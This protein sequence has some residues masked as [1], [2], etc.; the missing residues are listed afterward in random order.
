M[1]TP[2]AL[3][4]QTVSGEIRADL[5]RDTGV[6]LFADSKTG[7]VS[8][9]VSSIQAT[10]GASPQ[11]QTRLGKGG[12]T[13]K[14]LSQA[15][16]V[17]V[18]IRGESM[19]RIAATGPTTQ[20]EKRQAIRSGDLPAPTQ[21]PELIGQSKSTIA[22]GT[23]ANPTNG[24]EEISEGD[25]IRVD[26]ELVSVNVSV[27]DRNTNRGVNDLSKEDF[28]LFED[29]APQQIAHFD[30]AS[31]PFNLVLLIDLSGSTAKVVELIKAAAQHFVEAARP[32]DRIGD[33]TFPGGQVLVS[34][35]TSAHQP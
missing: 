33:V 13:V 31:A 12:R 16:N 25:V 22:A 1:G 29:N 7:A 18:A 3:L 11:L 8:S 26:T 19:P 6:D 14:L 9:S 34:S 20:T 17:T 27:V 5:D 24:P 2:A 23:P 32:F 4:I 28:R 35:L 21:R 15:G 10:K 30:S